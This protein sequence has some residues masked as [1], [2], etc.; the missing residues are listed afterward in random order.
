MVDAPV[1]SEA[2]SEVPTTR[3]VET[4]QVK[5]SPSKAPKAKKSNKKVTPTPKVVAKK[6]V[7]PVKAA[8]PT[9][10]KGKKKM[11]EKIRK[12]GP[13]MVRL[14]SRIKVQYTLGECRFR[15]CSKKTINKR[16]KWCVGHKKAIRKAQLKANNKVWNARV[17]KGTAGH[18]VVYDGGATVW[19]LSHVEK[20]R[21]AVKKG[22]S[23]V[24]TIKELDAI[25]KKTPDEIRKAVSRG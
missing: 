9:K 4:T 11:I 24:P 12:P 10:E 15:G 21:Q 2:T 8:T 1:T 19:T 22:A 17:K 23:I 25:I 7:V 16:A 20:A 13:A 14:I 5:A 6:A 18:H 3:I